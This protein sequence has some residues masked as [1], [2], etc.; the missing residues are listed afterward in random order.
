MMAGLLDR[1]AVRGDGGVLVLR[2]RPA[3]GG[4][5]PPRGA[6][7][8]DCRA[9]RRGKRRGERPRQVWVEKMSDGRESS[10][11][12]VSKAPEMTSKPRLHPRR[13]MSLGDTRVLPKRGPAYRQHDLDLGSRTERTK[14]RPETT[15][16]CGV[17]R[18]NSKRRKPRGAEYRRG[19]AGGLACSSCDP[20]AYRSGLGSKGAGPSGLMR[21]INLRE[22]IAWV[23]RGWKVR[24]MSSPSGWCGMRG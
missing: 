16:A 1:G 21:V 12:D 5:K 10:A 4:I 22:G 2:C 13:G 15:T 19:R 14:A 3:G 9:E 24:R 6:L 20:P 11:V 7:A 23:S 18:E 17:V 8:N